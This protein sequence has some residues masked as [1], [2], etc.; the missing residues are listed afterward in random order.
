MKKL[1]STLVLFVLLGIFS[2]S[3]PAQILKHDYK[4][5]GSYSAEQWQVH[6]L[7]F[8]GNAAGSA[9]PFDV[10]FASIFTG[11]GGEVLR[12]PGFYDGKDTWVARFSS[13][14]VG[15]WQFTTVSSRPEL[16]G[17]S[18]TVQIKPNTRPHQKGA[19]KIDPDNPQAFIYEDGSPYFLMAFELDWLFALDYDQQAEGLPR[20]NQLLDD[21]KAND[22]NHIVMNVYAH[23]VA[24]KIAE[25]VPQE[26][27]FGKLD[28]G[29]FEG[30]NENPDFEKLNLRLFR[31]LDKVL[32]AMQQR[33]LD[34]HLM[35][36][37]WNKLVNWPEMYSK[38]DNRYFDY[39]IDRYQA[40]S[41]VV[42][43]VS[44]EALD[45]GRCDVPY[46]HDRIQR[47]RQRDAY[48]RLLTVH[49][50]EYNSRHADK[51]DFVAIQSWRSNLYSLMLQG[52][53]KHPAKPVV[54]IEHGGYEEGPYVS[55]IGSY[56]NPETCL[57]RTYECV[58]AGVY[59]SYYWQDAAWNI[60]IWD[61]F[62]PK[63]DF[64]PPRY[65]YYRQLAGFFKK[66]DLNNFKPSIPKL[67][68][69]DKGGNDNLAT[70]GFAL[71]DDK[72]T[73]LMMIPAEA[74]R[75]PAVV[76]KPDSGSLQ[77]TWFNPFT[78]EYHDQG[79][80]QWTGWNEL[81]SPWQQEMSIVIIEEITK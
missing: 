46:I 31:Q 69:N 50:Y 67:T 6:D 1:I 11:P 12:V 71:Y 40:F 42:W 14:T 68:T 48:K 41:N 21:I 29:P 36:Y 2:L 32:E 13:A 77:I 7:V 51:V 65:D 23:D 9:N 60:V 10:E 4:N 17:L 47:I 54:N 74:E 28:Y 15:D 33:R 24:W 61:A 44:K 35:I 45:Y 79:K 53:Q 22:F 8:K 56:T 16:S 34:S 18:G 55:F 58:F 5:K 59:G 81:V 39:V 37:V 78:G 27:Y 72:G 20:T 80:I 76:P 25:D 70:N 63:H 38:A 66:Y 30:G 64:Q 52:R 49:D 26:Y 62:D 3:L 57:I 75:T 73:Y 19:V 43:D